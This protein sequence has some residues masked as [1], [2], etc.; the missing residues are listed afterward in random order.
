MAKKLESKRPLEPTACRMEPL[1][2]VISKL[3]YLGVKGLDVLTLV[4]RRFRPTFGLARFSHDVPIGVGGA[5][6]EWLLTGP[7]NDCE[8]SILTGVLTFHEGSM[9]SVAT[10]SMDGWFSELVEFSE[11]LVDDP[12]VS[13]WGNV[14]SKRGHEVVLK[15]SEG[16]GF[17]PTMSK[18]YYK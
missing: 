8:D 2:E 11:I 15:I 16:S 17:S 13:F 5:T 10:Q 3:D 1:F 12:V 6:F 14:V 4:P 7:G 18:T 9:F